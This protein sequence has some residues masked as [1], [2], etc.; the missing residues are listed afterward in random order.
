MVAYDTDLDARVA[1]IADAWGAERK[2]MFGGTG[3][4][5]AGNLAAGVYKDRLLIRLSAEEGDA[6]LA[7][8]GVK[9]FDMMPRP[10]PGWVTIGQEELVGDGLESWLARG[11]AHAESLPPK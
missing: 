4:M 3:Y 6:A 1:E 10:M 7:E 5:I 11:R 2:T 9:P 8:P